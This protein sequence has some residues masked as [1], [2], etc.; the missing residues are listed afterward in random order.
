MDVLIFYLFVVQVEQQHFRAHWE[1]LIQHVLKG[2]GLESSVLP[3]LFLALKATLVRGHAFLT[4][5]WPWICEH[6]L[7][8]LKSPPREYSTVVLEF[9]EFL[10][11]S[12]TSL[13][14]FMDEY[15]RVVLRAYPAITEAER[16]VQSRIDIGLQDMSVRP[17]ELV[18]EQR[19]RDDAAKML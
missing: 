2:F 13:T 17:G 19:V 18:L 1:W 10:V 5:Y 6:L 12:R 11:W 7:R 14:A 8:L 9:F 15:L 4:S 16:E 3:E